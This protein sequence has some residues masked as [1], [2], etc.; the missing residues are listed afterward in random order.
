MF[1]YKNNQNA[2]IAASGDSLNLIGPLKAPRDTGSNVV[3]N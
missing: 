1:G 2:W 3:S